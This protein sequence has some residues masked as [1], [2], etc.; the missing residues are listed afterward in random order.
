MAEPK[1]A[2]RSSLPPPRQAAAA[3]A[4]AVGAWARRPSGRLA[5]PALLLLILVAVTGAAG[6]LLV[7]ATAHT[8]RAAAAGTGEDPD[9][10]QP[11]P[12]GPD[13]TL[14]P[15]T[16][17]TGAPTAIPTGP[18]PGTGGRPADVL[19]SWAQQTSDRIGIPAVA[20]QAYGYTELVLA[21]TTPACRLTWT[22]LAAVG[23]VE[24]NHGRAN[25]AA[26]APDGQALPQIIGLPLDGNGGRQRIIDTDVGQLDGDR[27]FDRAVGPMQFIP[28]TW[29]Q[30]GVD[31]DN[32]GVKNPHDIDDAA[33][34]AGNY[35]CS[36]GR[37]LSTA[38]D[39]WNAILS[40]ND[41]RPYAQAVFDAAN[42]YGTASRT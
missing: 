13:L 38:A 39:W 16:P 4:R 31:A 3:A 12:T 19:A 29:Q 20:M 42:R 15:T 33:L 35:L 1:P 36:G 7:P 10:A 22:T 6:A 25:G 21:Q 9:I 41:V 17:S 37:D 26:L 30:S 8:E 2:A 24:S 34:A 32:D 14:A 23:L 18:P 11:T 5:L 28:S 40:Y 27:S